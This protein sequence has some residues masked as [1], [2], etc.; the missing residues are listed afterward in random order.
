MGAR[1]NFCEEAIPKKLS[2][3][4]KKD[5]LHKEEK[6]NKIRPLPLEKKPPH[7]YLSIYFFRGG[8]GASGYSCALPPPH[9]A[10]AHDLLIC[11]FTSF[12]I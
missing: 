10:G 7:G 3:R 8:R 9:P 4:G 5:L 1:R 11:V 12:A 2:I 6:H